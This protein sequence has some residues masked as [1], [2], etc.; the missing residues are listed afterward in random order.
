MKKISRSVRVLIGVSSSLTF[1]AV[2][3]EMH[4]YKI[5]L[6]YLSEDGLKT[7]LVGKPLSIT[8]SYVGRRIS[9]EKVFTAVTDSEGHA[10]F[11]YDKNA[12]DNSYARYDGVTQFCNKLIKT[13]QCAVLSNSAIVQDQGEKVV[14]VPEDPA[15]AYLHCEATHELGWMTPVSS[16]TVLCKY[17]K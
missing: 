11:T 16:I 5:D 4:T 3:A 9:Y 17:P 12:F 2:A 13:N 14:L 6:H 10:E 1:S 8:V 7:A 15:K